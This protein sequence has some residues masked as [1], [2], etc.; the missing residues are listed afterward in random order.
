MVMANFVDTLLKRRVVKARSVW[1]APPRTSDV[2]VHA[3]IIETVG[4]CMARFEDAV[5][6]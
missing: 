1:K 3:V 2:Q 6:Y 5:C 4:R